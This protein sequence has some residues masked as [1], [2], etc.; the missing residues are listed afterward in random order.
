[1]APGQPRDL[2]PCCVA[3]SVP[4]LGVWMD[5]GRQQAPDPRRSED[6]GTVPWEYVL[7]SVAGQ[8]ALVAGGHRDDEAPSLISH[9][10]L[11]AVCR[12]LCAECC[13]LSVAGCLRATAR[14]PPGWGSVVEPRTSQPSGGTENSQAW[15]ALGRLK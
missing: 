14:P 1:M 8:F 3:D 13:V 6:P 9:C 7:F 11:S 15:G 4:D 2:S 5:T 10:G 12:V